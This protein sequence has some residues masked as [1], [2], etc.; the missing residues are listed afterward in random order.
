MEKVDAYQLPFTNRS[1]E[2]FVARWAKKDYTFPAMSTVPMIGMILDATPLETQSIR[3]RF[4]KDWAVREFMKGDLART[5]TEKPGTYNSIH[6]AMTYTE[7]QLTPFIQMCLTP[8]PKATAKV[9]EV[10]TPPLEDVLS[11]DDEGE[12]VTRAVK[13]KKELH[14]KL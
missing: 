10:V 13:E 7:E 3:K 9:K 2:D 11:K 5:M 12:L 14:V 4:A 8:L 1:E 6:Q